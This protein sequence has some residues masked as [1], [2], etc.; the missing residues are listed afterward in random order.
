MRD[1]KRPFVGLSVLALLTV[2]AVLIAGCDSSSKSK[3]DTGGQ[4]GGGPSPIGSVS[5]GTSVTPSATA[6]STATPTGAATVAT[7]TMKF[8]P[9]LVD[10][11]GRTLY[12]FEKDR[13]N[14]SECT[15][16]CTSEWP[17]FHSSGM[18]KAG[19]GVQAALLGMIKRSDNTT[20]VTYNQH[21]LYYYRD[22]AGK[23]GQ[24]RGQNVSAFGAKWYVVAPNGNKVTGG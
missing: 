7:A 1:R 13:P 15:G 4:G 8:G 17:V 16:A 6:T 19:A 22:D 18:P 3:A 20:Q 24:I 21:P 9:I 14:V 10:G 12:L 23:P 5:P 11:S 2:G